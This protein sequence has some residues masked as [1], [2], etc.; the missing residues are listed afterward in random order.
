MF[1]KYIKRIAAVAAAALCFAGAAGC[2]GGNENT[3][4]ESVSV[5]S[6]LPELAASIGDSDRV[7]DILLSEIKD[8][9]AQRFILYISGIDVWGSPDIVSRSDVNLLL[10]VDRMAGKIQ[11]VNTPRDSYVLLPNSGDMKDKL[12]HAGLYGI[13]SS[14]GALENLYGIDIDYY[15]KLNFSGFEKFIDSLGGIDVNS[16]AD[17][18]VEPI[19]HYTKG[20]NH[21]TGLESLAFVRERKS[22]SDGDYQRGR[23]QMEMARAVVKALTSSKT[24]SRFDDFLKEMD[25]FYRTDM[26]VKLIKTMAKTELVKHRDWDIDVY[27]TS[28]TGDYQPTFSISSQNLYV[29]VLDEAQVKE[30]GDLLNKCVGR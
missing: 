18:T 6:H 7:I 26:P 24:L 2:I 22:F 11:V 5:E 30:A 13:E 17:F 29:T 20:I 4:E 21:L 27:T 19:K 9:N 14:E 28:G 10:A 16:E 23:H 3:E 15:L 25:D 12:T 1:K 8:D